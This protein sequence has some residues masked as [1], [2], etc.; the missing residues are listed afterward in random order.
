MRMLV[1]LLLLVVLL[2]V[3]Y[4]LVVQANRVRSG[5][6][7]R[8]VAAQRVDELR[9]AQWKPTHRQVEGHTEVVLQR[10][11]STAAGGTEVVE[12]RPFDRWADDDPMWEARFGEA[13]ANARYRCELMNAEEA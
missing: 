10:V 9:Q 7:N 2:V 11:R 3:A 12:E 1:P 8:Q 13:M 5:Q 4:W 6:A